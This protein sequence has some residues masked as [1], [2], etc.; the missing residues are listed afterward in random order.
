MTATQT[1]TVRFGELLGTAARHSSATFD[2]VLKDAETPFQEWVAM[3]LLTR[4]GGISPKDDLANDIAGRIGSDAAPI[5]GFLDRMLEKRLLAESD[6]NGNI[7]V[8]L[9]AEGVEFYTM[10]GARV[11]EISAFGLSTSSPE[12]IEA[13]RRVLTQFTE[14]AKALAAKP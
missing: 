12:D 2:Q 10:L 5:T 7:L 9:T 8:E 1:P 6:A 4:L 11:D 14:Q 13:A 3:T